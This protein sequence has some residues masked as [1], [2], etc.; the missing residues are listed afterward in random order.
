MNT[1]S[2]SVRERRTRVLQVIGN[3]IVGGMETFVARLCGSLLRDDGFEVV[4]LC[5]YESQATD[6]LQALGCAVH[7]APLP[8]E[9]VW[10]GIE[11]AAALVGDQE[12]DVIHAHLTNAHLLAGIV[13][14]LTS[15]PVLATIHG[16]DV[17]AADLAMQRMTDTHL[18]VVSRATFYQAIAAGARRDRTHCIIN[19]VDADLFRPGAASGALRAACG[20]DDDALLVGFVGRLSPEKGPELFVRSMALALARVPGLHAVMIGDGP[21]RFAV[22]RLV[23]EFGVADRLHLVGVR[24][25]IVDCLRSLTMLVSTSHSE[26]TPL[27]IMEAQATGIPGRRDARRRC[28]RDRHDGRDRRAR[29]AGRGGQRGQRGRGAVRGRREPSTSRTGRARAHGRTLRAPRP[30]RRDRGPPDDDRGREPAKPATRTD[31]R[32]GAVRRGP[33]DPRGRTGAAGA[34]LTSRRGYVAVDEVSP[35]SSGSSM[36]SGSPSSR[37]LAAYSSRRL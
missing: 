14:K 24:H 37:S 18:H 25:D 12:I 10:R 34:R 31:E 32:E 7:V 26:G 35:A 22:E 19:G 11:Y 23:A 33:R 2:T 8:D 20:V 6:A 4:C 29:A 15:T 28:A 9:P 3:A 36:S 30:Q 16:R 1:S 21:S 17:L 5:P 27:S 13:G